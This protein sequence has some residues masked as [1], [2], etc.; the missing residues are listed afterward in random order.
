MKD[1]AF[2]MSTGLFYVPGTFTPT[3]EVI[4]LAKAAGRFG[5]MHESH[6]RDDAAK[7]L[8]SVQRND[9]H[10]REGA[11][12]DADQPRQGHRR[13]ELGTQ[14]GHAARWSTRRGRAAW[15]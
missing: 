14:R 1:G 13:G 10:R 11:P 12:A 4:E 5:G 15:T 7:L 6:Q 8:D 3:D 2:G 9:R